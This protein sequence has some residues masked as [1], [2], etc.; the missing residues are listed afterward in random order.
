MEQRSNS[1]AEQTGF[2]QLRVLIELTKIR[3]VMA[4]DP[5]EIFS[6]IVEGNEIYFG[7]QTKNKQKIIHGKGIT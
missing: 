6:G 1:I 4:N 3:F 7:G 2:E 5:P